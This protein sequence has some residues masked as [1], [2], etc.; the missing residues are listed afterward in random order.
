MNVELAVGVERLPPKFLR[1][2]PQRPR[3]VPRDRTACKDLM[4]YFYYEP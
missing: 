4:R 1:A 2:I 3:F